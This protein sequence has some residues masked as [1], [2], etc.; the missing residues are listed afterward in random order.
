MIWW[1]GSGLL[2]FWFLLR[3]VIGKKGWVHLLLLAGITVLIIQLTAYRKTQ[4]ENRAR[5]R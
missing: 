1:I 3:F 5:G 2:V 4:Y